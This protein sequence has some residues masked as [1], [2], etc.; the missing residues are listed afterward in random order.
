MPT[1]DPHECIINFGSKKRRKAELFAKLLSF[2]QKTAMF[3]QI[4]HRILASTMTVHQLTM[5]MMMKSTQ[6]ANHH[7]VWLSV[8]TAQ[9][10]PHLYD[11][12]C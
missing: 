6:I 9:N 7:R 8:E 10:L 4:E 1:A 12:W 11:V 5:R 2:L 3:Y